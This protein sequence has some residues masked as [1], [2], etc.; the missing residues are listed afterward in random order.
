MFLIRGIWGFLVFVTCLLTFVSFQGDRGWLWSLTTHFHVQ[1]FAIQVLAVLWMFFQWIAAGRKSAAPVRRLA[2]LPALLIVSAFA[3]MNA[4][5][6][7]PYW[8]HLFQANKPKVSTVGHVR[9]MHFNLFGNRN[10]DV[11]EVVSAIR[12]EKPDVL[13]F[14]EYTLQWQRDLERSG[15]LS[16]YPYRIG[17]RGKLAL[18]SKRKLLKAH[19]TSDLVQFQPGNRPVQVENQVNLIAQMRVGGSPVTLLVAHPASPIAPSHLRW[20]QEM[21][22][23]WGRHRASLGKNLVLVGDLNTTPWSTEFRQIVQGTGLRDSQLDFGLQP[24][25]PTFF[26]FFN[27]PRLFSSFPSS[28][29]LPWGIPIDHVLVSEKIQVLSRKTGPFVGS[30]H[31]PL[32]VEFALKKPS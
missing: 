30:D 13:D 32:I 12:A 31:L 19:L 15:V 24:S 1:Y 7:A 21:F 9:L 14:V 22:K 6:I 28:L 17:G 8:G 2:K 16:A 10:H 20:Q 5:Q 26:L 23:G 25:W 3:C 11:S 29:R 4:W 27:V 18:Y